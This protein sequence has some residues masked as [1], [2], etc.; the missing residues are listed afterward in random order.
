LDGRCMQL[1]EPQ[2]RRTTIGTQSRVRLGLWVCP[3]ASA[4]ASTYNEYYLK[5]WKLLHL[6]TDGYRT[7]QA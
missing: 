4:A 1:N 6:P 2:Q 3:A 5:M 7:F